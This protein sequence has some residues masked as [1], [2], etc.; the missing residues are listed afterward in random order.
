MQ[1]LY[2][3]KKKALEYFG[4]RFHDMALV[5]VETTIGGL[6]VFHY[7]G[8]RITINPKDYDA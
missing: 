3:E 5:R 6:I 7:R 2:E 4:L 8:R 1:E